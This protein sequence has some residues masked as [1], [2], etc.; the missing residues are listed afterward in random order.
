[1]STNPSRARRAPIALLSFGA[2][3]CASLA[4]CA[5]EAPPPDEADAPART[6][7]ALVDVIGPGSTIVAELA[8]PGGSVVAFVQQPDGEL[9]MLEH[10]LDG[11]RPVSHVPELASA[12]PLEV[13]RAIDPFA[14]APIELHVAHADALARGYQSEVPVEFALADVPFFDASYRSYSSC[15]DI[16]AWRAATNGKPVGPNC[17]AIGQCLTNVVGNFFGCNP[18]GGCYP[19]GW[20]ERMRWSTCNLGTGTH[21]ATLTTF[22]GDGT[23]VSLVDADTHTAGAYYFYW[24]NVPGNNDNWTMGKWNL[25][26]ASSGHFSLWGDN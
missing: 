6:E 18:G 20:H 2:L 14:E 3:A 4:A 12:T 9:A 22:P 11:S 13:F 24:R 17:K 23:Y 5:V 19:T 1:M 16:N 21:T 25:A 8:S 7:H 15:T 26:G 10:G